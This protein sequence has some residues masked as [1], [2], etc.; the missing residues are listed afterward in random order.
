MKKTDMIDKEREVQKKLGIANGMAAPKVKKITVSM[1]V[2][3]ALKDKKNVEKMSVILTQITG[4][5]AK[6]TKAKKS[7]AAF[8]LREGEQ[9][10]VTV[11]LRGSIMYDFLGKLICVTLPRVRDFHGIPK[12]GFDGHGNYTLG[13]PEFTVFPEIDLGKIDRVQGMQVTIVTTGRNDEEGKALLATLG[14]PFEK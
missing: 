8:K 11:T 5:K 13:F 4:Q 12:K 7:V 14:L 2:Q 3:D 10:G 6:I 9:I 1:A